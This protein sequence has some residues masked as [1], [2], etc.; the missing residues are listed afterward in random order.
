MISVFK[1]P[2]KSSLTTGRLYAPLSI[3][4]PDR[5]A[6]SDEV[7]YVRDTDIAIIGGGLAGSAAAAMLGRAGIDTVLVDPHEVYPP[8]F[9]CEK[10]DEEQ[11]GLLARTGLGESSPRRRAPTG[12]N[13]IVRGGRLT[14]RKPSGQVG[15]L[16][17]R[18]VNTVRATIPPRS[19]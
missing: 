17:D 16:Y 4:G 1:R 18:L 8:D 15:I 2:T 11:I 12:E 9:R 7:R 10:L 13:W 5:C 19:R 6:G 3:S 14:D